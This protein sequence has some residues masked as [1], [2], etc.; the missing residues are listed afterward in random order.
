[1][2]KVY[3]QLYSHFD[4]WEPDFYGTPP[5]FKIDGKNEIYEL[6]IPKG[7]VFY[8]CSRTIRQYTPSSSEYKKR[9]SGKAYFFI[10]KDSD[11][12]K[13]PNY[14]IEKLEELTQACKAKLKPVK[15]YKY[16]MERLLQEKESYKKHLAEIE[17]KIKNCK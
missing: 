12:D 6:K 8:T 7:Y 3:I 5:A 17:G 9:Y 15:A 4:S 10:G 1:M 13:I 14:T 2:Q 11:Q 16:K